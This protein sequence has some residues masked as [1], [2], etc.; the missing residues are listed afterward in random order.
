MG[1]GSTSQ[2][3]YLGGAFALFGVPAAG[4]DIYG[5]HVGTFLSLIYS[6]TRQIA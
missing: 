6:A 5:S 3:K 4:L 2:R 1:G